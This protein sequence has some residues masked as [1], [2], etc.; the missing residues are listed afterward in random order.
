MIKR[1]III[2]K[3]KD[4]VDKKKRDTTCCDCFDFIGATRVA[5]QQWEEVEFGA[6]VDGVLQTI[7]GYYDVG[8]RERNENCCTTSQPTWYDT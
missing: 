7:G 6:P 5:L 8:D 1:E 3:V 2:L 4:F